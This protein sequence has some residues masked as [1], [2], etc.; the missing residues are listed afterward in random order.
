L[1]YFWQR[2]VYYIVLIPDIII[3]MLFSLF[4]SAVLFVKEYCSKD[5]GAQ[6][7]VDHK[8]II[9]FSLMFNLILFCLFMVIKLFLPRYFLIGLPFIA[10]LFVYC[11]NKLGKNVVY[12]VILFMISFYALNMYGG[13]YNIISKR[14]G[15]NGYILERT[16]E[17]EDDM[18][19]NIA[20]TRLIESEYS[21]NMIIVSWP[22]AHMLISPEF[23]YVKDSIEVVSSDHHVFRWK[24]V[25]GRRDIN[26]SDKELSEKSAVWVWSNNCY[27]QHTK[28]EKNDK[29]LHIIKIN[30]REIVV[31]KKS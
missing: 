28:P 29:I 22:L 10:I 14:S 27:S 26:L 13:I 2:F 18:E 16:L 5:V 7:P 17:Y 1:N 23:G 6:R 20:L 30:N 31:Y 8:S 3:L 9:L 21:D 25:K 12:F 19:A 4:A 24:G 11:L 15:N